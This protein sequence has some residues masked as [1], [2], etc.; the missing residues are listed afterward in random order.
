MAHTLKIASASYADVSKVT[1]IDTDG[2]SRAYLDADEVYTKDQAAQLIKDDRNKNKELLIST[3]DTDST[4]WMGDESD[5]I[6]DDSA[7]TDTYM[8][9]IEPT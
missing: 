6:M 2:T 1:F 5:V 3:V 8:L 4:L 7:P 9:W